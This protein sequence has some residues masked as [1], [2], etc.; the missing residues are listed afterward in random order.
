LL[1][2]TGGSSSKDLMKKENGKKGITTE[3]S[4]RHGAIGWKT[5]KDVALLSFLFSA[6]LLPAFSLS[7]VHCP[8]HLATRGLRP[9]IRI[10]FDHPVLQ[11]DGSIRQQRIVKRMPKGLSF[12]V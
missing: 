4:F 1:S 7:F 9:Q 3:T 8:L 12:S 10:L 11:S 2:F 5:R 6:S